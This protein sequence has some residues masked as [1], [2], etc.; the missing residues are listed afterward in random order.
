MIS[1]FAVLLLPLLLAACTDYLKEFNDQYEDSFADGAYADFDLAVPK[2]LGSEYACRIK[3]TST[4]A[5]VEIEQPPL[6]YTVYEW[7]TENGSA[8]EQMTMYFLNDYFGDVDSLCAEFSSHS[9]IVPGSFK[10]GSKGVAS[11]EKSGITMDEFLEGVN[12][13]CDETDS[14][15]SSSSVDGSSARSSSSSVSSSSSDNGAIGKCYP[16]YDI[17]DVNESVVWEFVNASLTNEEIKNAKFVWNFQPDGYPAPSREASIKN[18]E[19][20][21][22]SVKYPALGYWYANLQVSVNGKSYDLEC[23]ELLVADATEGVYEDDYTVVDLRDGHEYFKKKIGTQTWMTENMKYAPPEVSSYC[24]DNNIDNC[25]LRYGRLYSWSAAQKACP[26]GWHLPSKDEWNALYSF[27]SQDVGGDTLIMAAALKSKYASWNDN[28]VATD[29]YGFAAWPA[30]YVGDDNKFA[31]KGS[32][33]AFWTSTSNDYGAGIGFYLNAY[34][35]YS[36]IDYSEA[37][38]LSVRCIKD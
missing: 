11:T 13:L 20:L 7:Y 18:G 30:G 5:L 25:N 34:N 6:M 28:I 23:G 21:S 10:C 2:G 38:A 19:M 32:A 17:I 3:K 33:A 31:E 15:Y 8:Y 26:N 27:V 9:G 14:Q 37:N 24:N 16:Y 35:L 36:I 22:D 4:G 12:Y 29:N 1:S